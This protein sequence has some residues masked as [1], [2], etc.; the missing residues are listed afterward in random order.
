MMQ[1]RPTSREP[2]TLRLYIAGENPQ[3][4]L[5][6]DNLTRLCETHL[7]E[8]RYQIEVIDLMKNPQLAKADQILAIPT[9][10]RRV[11]EPVRRVIGSLSNA[12]RALLALDLHEL[13]DEP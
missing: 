4:R 9:L 6:L 11:P 2:W 10:V 12:D 8:G 7:G 3:S 1:S 13:A 5:A